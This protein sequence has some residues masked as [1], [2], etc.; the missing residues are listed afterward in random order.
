MADEFD[1]HQTGLTS[2]AQAADGIVPD[3]NQPLAFATRAIYVGTGGS[4]RVTLV[5]G[6][7]VTLQGTVAGTVYPLR[8][9]QVHQTGT[10]AADLIGLR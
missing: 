5:G 10:T 2:P 1:A 4:L 8:I 6:T 7:T 3:D 9:A